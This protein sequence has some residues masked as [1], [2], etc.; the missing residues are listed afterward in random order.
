[1]GARTNYTIVTTKNPEQNINIYSHWDGE[2]SVSILQN[3]VRQ[4]FPRKGDPSYQARIIIDQLTKFG[5]DSET[6]YGIYIGSEIQAEEEY[7]YKE[8][9]LL[10]NTVTIGEMT[11][12]INDF[13]KAKSLY[14]TE[15]ELGQR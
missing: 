2:E 7:H 10:T 12:D 3:A 5:R 14:L 13:L 15:K 9:N 4:S 1:M 8:V 6:G 11:F